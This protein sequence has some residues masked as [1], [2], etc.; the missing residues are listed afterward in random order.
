MKLYFEDG[1]LKFY[2]GEEATDERRQFLH[3]I[4]H[5]FRDWDNDPYTQIVQVESQYKYMIKEAKRHGVEITQ[6]VED[7]YQYTLQKEEEERQ[8]KAKMEAQ[9][10]AIEKG[11]F[12]QKNGCGWC[13]YLEYVPGASHVCS[14]AKRACRYRQFDLDYEFEIRKEVK[15]FGAPIVDDKVFIAPPY[16]CA[17]CKF[18]EEAVKAW[19]EIN[20]EKEGNV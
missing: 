12:K 1:K 6:D 20:K 17:G 2:M 15:A 8:R 16:P 11:D 13:E 18:L 4:Y 19:E 10:K 3:D 14:Y 7:Y 9:K 5:I